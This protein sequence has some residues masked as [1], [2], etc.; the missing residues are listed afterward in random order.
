MQVLIDNVEGDVSDFDDIE[1]NVVA[2][3]PLSGKEFI[4]DGVD[5]GSYFLVAFIVFDLGRGEFIEFE[6]V[7]DSNGDG[8]PDPIE[9]TNDQR[10]EVDLVLTLPEPLSVLALSPTS[11]STGV[12]TETEIE[13]EF[14]QPAFLMPEDIQILPPPSGVGDLISNDDGSVYAVRGRIG[15][16]CYLSRC[17]RVCRGFGGGALLNPFETVFTTGNTF[18]E[19]S[20]IRGRLVL[21]NLP[22]SRR[23]DGPLFVGAVPAELLESGTVGFET[24]SEEDLVATTITTSPEFVIEDVPPGDY[25]VAAFARVEVPKGFR[26]PDP[27]QRALGDFD[28]A[29]QGRFNEQALEVFDTIELFGIYDGNGAGVEPVAAGEEGIELFLRGQSKTRAELLLVDEFPA[30]RRALS[31][32]R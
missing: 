18:A 5:P 20:S 2:G 25:L 1:D 32:C 24:F 29:R 17:G 4:M 3:V 30:A 31:Q 14:N 9:L 26:A 22:A 6:A 11:R 27:R 23:F 15:R 19:L 21:P 28:I 13:I 10:S 12:P 16:R 8:L 7:F